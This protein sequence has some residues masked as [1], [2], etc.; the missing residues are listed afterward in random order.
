MNIKRKKLI[1]ELG[2]DPRQKPG[3]KRANGALLIGI[4]VVLGLF[5]LGGIVMTILEARKMTN[6]GQFPT[7]MGNVEDVSVNRVRQRN[8]SYYSLTIRYNFSLSGQ[9]Y[10]NASSTSYT[11]ESEARSVAEQFP[12]GG[13]T[14]V[15]YDPTNPTRSS[16]FRIGL[17][18]LS[19]PGGASAIALI[20]CLLTLWMGMGMFDQAKQLEQKTVKRSPATRSV[21]ADKFTFE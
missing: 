5:A 17:E 20:A 21:E 15:W 4:A 7:A 13:S 2:D 11:F 1:E 12:I 19:L 9:R 16:V 10:D 8:G 3:S 6:D 18:Y 14:P